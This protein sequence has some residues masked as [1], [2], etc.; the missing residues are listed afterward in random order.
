MPDTYRERLVI[1]PL[2][3]LNDATFTRS[4]TNSWQTEYHSFESMPSCS[5]DFYQTTERNSKKNGGRRPRKFS[6]MSWEV[7]SFPKT[8]TSSFKSLPSDSVAG[9]DPNTVKRYVRNHAA[10]SSLALLSNDLIK[11]VDSYQVP[12]FVLSYDPTVSYQQGT[13]ITGRP[14]WVTSYT[15]I[16]PPT[17]VPSNTELPG[18]PEVFWSSEIAQVDDISRSKLYRKIK[19]Q[20]ADLGTDFAEAH[21]TWSM[22]IDLVTRFK[23]AALALK[24]GKIRNG[25]KLIAPTT[26]R[27]LANDFLA[28][29]YGISP[30]VSD[31]A[32]LAQDTISLLTH[33][34]REKRS[35]RSTR[36]F[37]KVV[38]DYL[39]SAEVT[40]K[41]SA[42]FGV[43]DSL[44]DY[45]NRVGLTNPPAV[46]WEL[47][48][49]SFVVDWFLPIGPF[50]SAVTSLDHL[51]I[52]TVHKTLVIRTNVSFASSWA[53]RH[54]L[55][56]RD[57]LIPSW[58][59]AG[60]TWSDGG[61]FWGGTQFF[62]H[63]F[64]TSMPGIPLPSF[65]SPFSSGHLFNALALVRQLFK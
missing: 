24:K 22:F 12:I 23:D 59:V 8:S 31:V 48:P 52:K 29:R 35:A 53:P 42:Y 60:N 51:D 16:S 14:D 38:G 19:D 50:L 13:L 32:G 41:Y 26:S 55:S 43:R 15:G 25:I 47:V 56:G 58:A 11:K 7:K 21:K 45:L 34:I 30:L 37:T 33:G 65:K 9:S 6:P 61:Y 40:V 18:N 28:Y 64:N 49:F 63:R 44:L 62:C 54:G 5:I 36:L 17:V 10:S 1:L 46:V 3:Y 20:P 4:D 2:G 39:Y 27:R 57:G